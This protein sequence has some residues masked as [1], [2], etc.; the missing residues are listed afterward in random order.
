MLSRIRKLILDYDRKIYYYVVYGIIIILAVAGK[1]VIY[2]KDKIKI[3]YYGNNLYRQ[4]K[5]YYNRDYKF[6][7]K[8][9]MI[10]YLCH[11]EGANVGRLKKN[12]KE[13]KRNY[14]GGVFKDSKPA[15]KVTKVYSGEMKNQKKIEKV[16]E[17]YK[18]GYKVEVVNEDLDKF[19]NLLIS[20]KKAIW[21]KVK[22]GTEKV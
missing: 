1:K 19:G 21:L 16:K 2:S 14:V 3:K 4:S 22:E 8:K 20:F 5:F 15:V 12:R 6:L 11:V 10:I 17:T 7:I 9:K 18:S 13:F